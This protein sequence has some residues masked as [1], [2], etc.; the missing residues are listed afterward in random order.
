MS[1]YVD[2]MN[3]PQ[4]KYFN[5]MIGRDEEIHELVSDTLT[6]EFLL[7]RG[8]KKSRSEGF[9]L[10]SK[11]RQRIAG[12]LYCQE[13]DQRRCRKELA[14]KDIR[15]LQKTLDGYMDMLLILPYFQ[16][17]SMEKERF[18][19][20]EV[21]STLTAGQLERRYK[22]DKENGKY[23]TPYTSVPKL[24]LVNENLYEEYS[25][26]GYN[27]KAQTELDRL[28]SEDVH[29]IITV[30]SSSQAELA[31]MVGKK[32]EAGLYI[33]VLDRKKGTRKIP[34]EKLLSEQNE[35]TAVLL[36]LQDYLQEMELAEKQRR[37]YSEEHPGRS[38]QGKKLDMYERFVDKNAIKVFDIKDKDDISGFMG[39]LLYL[40]RKGGRGAS[41]AVGYEMVPHTRKGHY[42]TYKSG[43]TVYVK[44]SVIHKEKYQ[45]IQ[46]AHRINQADDRDLSDL[47]QPAGNTFTQ[48]IGM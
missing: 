39:G 48:G 6:G 43:K 36:C 38:T 27:D 25:Q 47:D 26:R 22:R 41:R 17:Q 30:Q 7:K 34:L 4:Y 1:R 14:T 8:D 11:S 12:F 37:K 19:S 16:G 10:L 24:L 45:G 40:S 5:N 13:E 44:A 29:Y 18:L 46:S 42:R 21:R 33:Q 23:Y 9:L 32:D 28:V 20:E 15:Q 2:K 3:L 31:Y 35:M